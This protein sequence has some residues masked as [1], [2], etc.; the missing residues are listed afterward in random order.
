LGSLL[1]AGGAL[2]AAAVTGAYGLAAAKLGA[3]STA[4][5]SQ[6]LMARRGVQDLVEKK[7]PDKIALLSVTARVTPGRRLY[8]VSVQWPLARSTKGN[9]MCQSPCFNQSWAAANDAGCLMTGYAVAVDAAAPADAG[10][11]QKKGGKDK[12]D[13]GG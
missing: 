11:D 5:S 10:K 6:P 13:S 9:D 4:S 1:T 3:A 8:G 2:G 12:G 7:V